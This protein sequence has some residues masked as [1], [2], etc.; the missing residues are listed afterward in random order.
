[1][2]RDI[3]AR[4]LVANHTVSGTRDELH[5]LVVISS[6]PHDLLPAEGD[7][8]TVNFPEPINPE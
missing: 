3:S 6:P 7:T 5:L 1:M 2:S 4:V 8:L